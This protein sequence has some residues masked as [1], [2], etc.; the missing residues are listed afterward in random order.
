MK[1]NYY[2]DSS[3]EYHPIKKISGHTQLWTQKQV[4]YRIFHNLSGVTDPLF[5]L[6]QR[7][8]M[9]RIRWWDSDVPSKD[10]DA[11]GLK[12]RGYVNPKRVVV[13]YLEPPPIKKHTNPVM[14]CG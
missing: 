10:V 1:N 6:G 3:G 4:R 5:I 11:P 2:K 13:N 14:S 9:K 12:Y 7:I 8:V